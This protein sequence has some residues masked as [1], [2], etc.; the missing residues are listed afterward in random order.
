MSL[1]FVPISIEADTI[2]E[3]SFMMGLINQRAGIT[4][5]YLTQYKDEARNKHILVY[6]GDAT[7]MFRGRTE[8]TLKTLTEK[9]TPN[10]AAKRNKRP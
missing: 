4:H 8:K 2:E 9:E 10:G 5:K 7:A 6:L 3:L 1:W